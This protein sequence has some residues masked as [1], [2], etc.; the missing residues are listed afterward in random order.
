MH[1]RRP[2]SSTIEI[3][4]GGSGQSTRLPFPLSAMPPPP[5]PP[6]PPPPA[7]PSGP[8]VLEPS[9]LGGELLSDG[10]GRSDPHAASRPHPRVAPTTVAHAILLALTPRSESA[11]RPR[12]NRARGIDGQCPRR[13]LG[14]WTCSQRSMQA[15][16]SLHCREQSA[17][18]P[19]FLSHFGSRSHFIGSSCAARFTALH[20][21]RTTA[22]ATTTPKAAR[23]RRVT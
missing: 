7:S 16:S 20:A 4:K 3:P 14:A 11:E 17:V 12:V 19:R 13:P 15:G 8:S 21:E 1:S 10:G 5:S 18:R 6:P 2:P 22:L 23:A 9:G